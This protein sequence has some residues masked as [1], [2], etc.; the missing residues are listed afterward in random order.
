MAI[1]A[2]AD[3]EVPNALKNLT[4]KI[5]ILWLPPDTIYTKDSLAFLLKY[6]LENKIAVM[7]FAPYL[8]KAGALFCYA[9]DFVNVGQQAG[10]LAL[11]IFAGESA[12]K[13]PLTVPRKVTFVLNLKVAKM[14]NVNILNSI[15]NEASEIYQ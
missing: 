4:G 9:Y 11:K 3:I 1:K 10:E 2:N 13:L 15:R 12:G 7:G 8:A 5:D 6:C 14:L